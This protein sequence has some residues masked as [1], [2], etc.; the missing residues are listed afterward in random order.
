MERLE[1]SSSRA[2]FVAQ[3]AARVAAGG[4]AGLP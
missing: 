2:G 3:M 4:H 1:G